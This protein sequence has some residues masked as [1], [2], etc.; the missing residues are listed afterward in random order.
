MS[1][2]VLIWFEDPSFGAKMVRFNSRQ[3]PI[4][5][6][7]RTCSFLKSEREKASHAYTDRI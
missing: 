6:L 7:M 4:L 3:E 5:F 2:K 1:R